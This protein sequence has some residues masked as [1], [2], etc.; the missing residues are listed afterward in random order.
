[1]HNFDENSSG[2]KLLTSFVANFIKRFYSSRLISFSH[3]RIT[4]KHKAKIE[5]FFTS[6][7]LNTFSTMPSV[8]VPWTNAEVAAIILGKQDFP[9]KKNSVNRWRPILDRY[10]D[11]FHKTRDNVKLKDKWDNCVKK[12]T[13][14]G[15]YPDLIWKDERKG[16]LHPD[17]VA[18][19]REVHN[20]TYEDFS[21]TYKVQNRVLFESR[22]Q[23]VHTDAP[24]KTRTAEQEAAHEDP[25]GQTG[26][27]PSKRSFSLDDDDVT[28]SV[29]TPSPSRKKMKNSFLDEEL[30]GL[31]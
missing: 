25:I 7:H 11:N 20:G 13:K 3:Y 28:V 23:K 31:L 16:V 21:D 10:K 18:E 26:F 14:N 2:R 1:M 8:L 5:A 24:S 17:L 29:V 6:T 22:P 30:Y 4:K 9:K 15:V 12:W 27:R 19:A